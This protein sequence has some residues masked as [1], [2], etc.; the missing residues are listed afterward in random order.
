MP[1]ALQEKHLN[2]EY[3]IAQP[4]GRTPL[5]GINA[6]NKTPSGYQSC[7]LVN[8]KQANISRAVPLTRGINDWAVRLDHSYAAC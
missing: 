4:G 6:G 8:G 7:Q 3:D 5:D 2:F 1:T